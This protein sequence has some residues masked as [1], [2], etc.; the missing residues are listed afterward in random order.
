MT[1]A[2]ILY[3]E[4]LLKLTRWQHFYLNIRTVYDYCLGP[5]NHQNNYFLG[6]T[7]ETTSSEDLAE[8]WR[9]SG[10]T[11]ATVEMIVFH[12]SYKQNDLWRRSG[13]APAD[14]YSLG[15]GL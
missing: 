15:Y 14:D 6:F 11:S 4:T 7:S 10:E 5:D 2:S 8:I 13:G 9:S 3:Y 1:T 12:W